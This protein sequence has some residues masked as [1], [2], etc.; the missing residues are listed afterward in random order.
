MNSIQNYGVANYQLNS[1]SPAFKCKKQVTANI[2]KT[3]K[4]LKTGDRSLHDIPYY[5]QKLTVNNM[6]NILY[7]LAPL[8]LPVTGGAIAT[9]NSANK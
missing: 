4:E 6:P 2:V 3:M 7:Y 8:A 1:N 5:R 9:V